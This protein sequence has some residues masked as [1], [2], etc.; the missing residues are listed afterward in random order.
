MTTIFDGVDISPTTPTTLQ[1]MLPFG[2]LALRTIYEADKQRERRLAA[3]AQGKEPTT[4]REMMELAGVKLPDVRLVMAELLGGSPELM[5]AAT[6]I[7]ENPDLGILLQRC[8]GLTTTPGAPTDEPIVTPPPTHERRPVP[9]SPPSSPPPPPT[10]TIQ[11]STHSSGLSKFRADFTR[12]VRE[13]ARVAAAATTTTTP[14]ASPPL[15]RFRADL[16]R[17]GREA[18]RAAA[19]SATAAMAPPLPQFRPDFTREGREAAK[20]AAAAATSATASTAPSSPTSRSTVAPSASPPNSE[21][22]PSL[23][24]MVERQLAALVRT[25]NADQAKIDER[26]RRAEV[27]LAELRAE[28]RELIAQRA[29]R[30][31]QPLAPSTLETQPKHTSPVDTPTPT[32]DTTASSTCTETAIEPVSS[33]PTELDTASLT[34]PAVPDGEPVALP[35]S[36][37]EAEIVQVVGMI[38]VVSEQIAAQN[39]RNLERVDSVEREVV[40]VKSIV[41]LL[42]EGEASIAPT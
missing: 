17:E 11:S 27:E 13:A 29:A 31:P 20:A 34:E 32:I 42:R 39:H 25:V 40:A 38:G 10:A 21:S 4:V 36:A 30:D 41:T 24:A 8:A 5:Q 26:L 12:E 37:S 22:R 18:A 35:P 33:D 23:V 9:P 1:R 7:E 14:P 16:T 19:S 2:L 6:L 15:P 28:L 3:R